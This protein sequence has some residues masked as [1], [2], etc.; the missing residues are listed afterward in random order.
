MAIRKIVT[1]E[2]PLL[3]KKSREIKNINDHIKTLAQD[4]IDTLLS[5]DNGIGLAGPQV[6]VL[7]R[8]FVIDMR[9]GEGPTVYI[10]PEII[11]K[12]DREVHTEGC[13]SIPNQW[14][15]ISRPTKVKVRATNVDGE[16]FEKEVTG[17]EAACVEH[18]TDHL[19]G[20]LYVDRIKT[21]KLG[22][23]IG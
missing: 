23:D 21:Q 8:I 3:R 11:S 4:M 10:N 1:E 5:T 15:E 17:L 2:D 20:M 7:R 14:E 16:D 13:L 22:L 9:E 12:E 6:G 19:N 18:E